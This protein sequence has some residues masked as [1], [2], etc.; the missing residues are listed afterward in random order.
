MTDPI[1]RTGTP[2]RRLPDDDQRAAILR[3]AARV[4]NAN[5]LGASTVPS[6]SLYPHQWSWDAAFISIGRSWYDEARARLELLT[7]F[8]AQWSNGMLPHIIFFNPAIPIGAYF[9]GPDFWDSRRSPHAPRDR[10]TSGITQPPIHAAAV[11]EMHRHA[12]EVD[13]STAFLEA[14]YP[15]LV[16]Q[17]D[18]LSRDRDPTSIGL[19][20]IVHPWESGLDDSPA[21]DRLLKGLAMP[22]GERP[23]Y[24]RFDTD[25]AEAADRPT[26]AAYDAFVYLAARYRDGGY[27]D[28]HLLDAA[29]FAIAGPLFSAIYLWSTHALAEIATLIGADPGPHREAAGRI[30]RAIVDHLWDADDR[31]FYPRDLQSNRLEPEET[32]VSSP[33]CWIRICRQRWSTPCASGWSRSASI[34][35]RRSTSSSRRTASEAPASIGAVT[36]AGPCGSTRTGCSGA[37]CACMVG[38][39]WRT[40]S[41]TAVSRSSGDP[42]SANT[43][44]PSMDRGTVATTSAGAPPSRSTSS[45]LPRDRAN[46]VSRRTCDRAWP[47]CDSRQPT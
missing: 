28:A 24:R 25:H 46:V 3:D 21:W 16:A 19:P 33:P 34:P 32:I 7:L 2:H 1:D 47:A 22:P 10:P 4:L 14:I 11:L 20:A 8:D 26:D 39:P 31:A 36:G 5:W 35:T 40:R 30:G 29:P 44:S 38:P 15:R 42:G 9:P 17:H 43:S 6:R 13:G 45:G 37:A 27:D 12:V 41:R 23:T 18:Y